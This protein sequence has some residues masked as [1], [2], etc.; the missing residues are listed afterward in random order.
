MEDLQRIVRDHGT[1]TQGLIRRNGRWAIGVYHRC[2]GTLDR[3]RELLG[4][5]PPPNY[6][7]HLEH[8][9]QA[10]LGRWY[11]KRIYDD[12]EMLDGLRR[13][14]AEKGYLTRDLID[15]D[16]NLPA[17]CTYS[18]RFGGMAEVYSR[19][20]Y[21]PRGVQLNAIRSPK[22][23]ARPALPLAFDR[24]GNLRMLGPPSHPKG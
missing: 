17:A 20:G 19:V 14:F 22:K 10:N 16:P 4:V 12:D 8:I 9:R 11:N 6:L 21:E 7:R 18:Q 1:L 24:D 23:K 5:D 15:S 2:L 3:M 13:L